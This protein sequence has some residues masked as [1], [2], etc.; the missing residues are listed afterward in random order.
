MLSARAERT[1]ESAGQGSVPSG[2][3]LPGPARG[4]VRDGQTSQLWHLVLNEKRGFSALSSTSNPL[5]KSDFVGLTSN[6]HH[7]MN[8]IRVHLKVENSGAFGT[9]TALGSHHLC[10]APGHFH[11]PPTKGSQYRLGSPAPALPLPAPGSRQPAPCPCG[12]PV[13]DGSCHGIR[14]VALGVCLFTHIVF[15]GS[16]C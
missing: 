13:P 9:C 3:R 1:L 2:H 15:R 6:S 14:Y 8:Y 4:S 10:L 7:R 12:F 11:H 16:S 5:P